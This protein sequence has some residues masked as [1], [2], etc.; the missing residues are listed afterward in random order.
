MPAATVVP[1]RQ[2]TPEWLAARLEG[3]GASE[4]SAA[5]GVSPWQSPIG[6]WAEKLGLTPP[7]AETLPMRIGSELEPLIARLYTEQTGAKVRRVNML[8]QHPTHP[9]MLASIDRRAG[10]RLVE[11]KYSLRGTGYG[12][13]GT[14]EVPDEVLVQ[15]LHQMAVSDVDEA[16]VAAIIGGRQDV[17]IYPIRRSA[18][19][20]AAIVE[21]E[22]EFWD[23]VQSRT[24]PPLDGSEATLRALAAIYPRDDGE[25]LEAD[26]DVGLSLVSYHV[27]S[28]AIAAAEEQKAAARARI[29]AFM[30]T[31]SKLVAPGVGSVTW[32]TAK[33][34][35]VVDW[36]GVADA[37][38][39]VI[40]RVNE[41]VL[42]NPEATEADVRALLAE[43]S[44]GATEAE[45]TTTRTGSRR[46]LPK[47][48]EE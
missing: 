12:E 6:L 17:Q 39:R 26:A 22:A 25:V 14:D 2:R 31:A 46:F 9:F 47:L 34:S 15:V 23:H 16:D 5:I 43:W 30:G 41:W 13:P 20:E 35:E 8:R 4:A 3:I 21:R 40:D 27:S 1:V 44:A 29:E 19:A 18:E 10:K 42:G 24:E 48:E 7:Q 32:K 38:D 45:H 33:D 36:K 37:Y 28:Q 11:L